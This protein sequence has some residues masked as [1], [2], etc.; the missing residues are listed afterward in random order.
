MLPLLGVYRKGALMFK[1]GLG[2]NSEF[3]TFHPLVNLAYYVG[4]ITVTMFSMS[5]IFLTLS[6][7]FSWF[8]S[9]LLKGGKIIKLNLSLTI[10]TVIVMAVINT[11]FTH[12][13]ETV[14][15]YIN[16]NR[17]TMEAFIYG[18]A[19]ATMLA[20]VIIWFTSFNVIMSA[21]KL[22]YLFG[23]TAPVLGLTLSM[24][25]RFVPLLKSRFKEI[26]MGQKAMG[27]NEIKGLVPKVR[28][29]TKEVSILIAWS[30]EASIESADSMEARGYG[31]HGR[32]SFHLY[33]ITGRDGIMLGVIGILT[34]ILGVG[35][36][37]GKTTMIYYPTLMME[38]I[39]VVTIVC[40]GAYILLM[41]LP[42]ILDI[43][44]E[45][46]WKQLA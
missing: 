4:V 3:N 40:I 5:P 36:Y 7:T 26:S 17:I 46:K 8:Y 31:L 9:I 21:D 28:Q 29:L 45:I 14:W 10:S 24:I 18:I 44:G 33:K 41:S 39:D 25:F 23:K 1:E 20:S 43:R 34:F 11:L 6:L 2:E 35:I 27:R 42:M 30:L 32:T 16:T 38:K 37:L 12:S 19:S 13:G 22:I 15:F